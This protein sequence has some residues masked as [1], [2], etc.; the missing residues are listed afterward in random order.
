MSSR[1]ET[2]FRRLK[3]KG[4]RDIE[5]ARRIVDA[6]RMCHVGFS[7]REQPYVLPMA[8]AREGDRLLLHVRSPAG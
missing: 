1:P 6:A 7:V 4:S 8:I 3:E 5:L 2:R